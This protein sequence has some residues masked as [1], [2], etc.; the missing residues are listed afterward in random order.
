MPRRPLVELNDCLTITLELIGRDGIANVK[1]QDIARAAGVTPSAL[2]SRFGSRQDLLSKALSLK[3]ERW[4]A[5]IARLRCTPAS[6]WLD[7]IIKL[8]LSPTQ[9]Q[10]AAWKRDWAVWYDAVS[11]A[12]HDSQVALACRVQNR[13]WIESFE[14]IFLAGVN[15]GSLNLSSPEVAAAALELTSLLD[16]LLQRLQFEDTPA[17]RRNNLRIASNAVADYATKPTIKNFGLD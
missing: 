2:I 12:R 16:G 1:M 17:V 5:E 8:T 6:R 3:D 7:R 4:L 13:Q 14:T 10:E 11:I 15:D 9:D